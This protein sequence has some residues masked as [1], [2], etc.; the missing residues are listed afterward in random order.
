MALRQA[1]FLQMLS[2]EMFKELMTTPEGSPTTD[3]MREG[4]VMWLEHI[5]TA[6]DW[7]KAFKQGDLD[8]LDMISTCLQ[9]PNYWTIRLAASISACPERVRARKVFGDR[10]AKTME[11]KEDGGA[12]SAVESIDRASEE[13]EAD[14]S[15]WQ[16][17][18][19][20]K[21]GNPI[22]VLLKRASNCW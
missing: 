4:V 17:S 22:G 8:E 19:R 6:K 1:G 12:I 14:F 15:G 9:S 7:N 20:F 3:D 11:G 10:I 18:K 13:A 16:R 5:Y 21:V 2:Y